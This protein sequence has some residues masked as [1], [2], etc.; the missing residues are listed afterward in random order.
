ML[1]Q[2]FQL[3]K[4]FAEDATL[5]AKTVMENQKELLPLYL[6]ETQGKIKKTRQKIK[7]YESGKKT[8]IYL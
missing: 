1:Q 3:N 4:R 5:Q 7:D 8:Q 6:K 2:V